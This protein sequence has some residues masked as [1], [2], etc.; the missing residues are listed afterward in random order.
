MCV[1]LGGMLR[2]G[3]EQLRTATP[4]EEIGIDG[5]D[6]AEI[7]DLDAALS[8]LEQIDETMANVVKLRYFAGL[9]VDETATA[10]DISPRAVNRHWTAARA[11]LTSELGL[12][13][14]DDG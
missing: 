6:A 3:G 14:E 12:G 9:K 5:Y 11:W 10:L 1:R 13:R 4:P 2:H 8:K 7:L